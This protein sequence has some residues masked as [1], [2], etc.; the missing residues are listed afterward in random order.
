MTNKQDV[1]LGEIQKKQSERLVVW[2]K[3]H[4]GYQYLDI[5]IF[6]LNDNGKWCFTRKGLTLLPSKA[7]ELASI[8]QQVSVEQ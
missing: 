5:R 8:L 3:E 6:A 1:V 2:L 4:Q 7:H